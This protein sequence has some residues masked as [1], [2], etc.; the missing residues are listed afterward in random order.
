MNPLI[1]SIQLS[2]MPSMTGGNSNKYLLLLPVNDT[3]P[4]DAASGGAGATGEPSA[5]AVCTL[6][7]AFGVIAEDHDLG[8]I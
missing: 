8:L 1:D 5:D 4:L 2:C 6:L 3:S 7:Q